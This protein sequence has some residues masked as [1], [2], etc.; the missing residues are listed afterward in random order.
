VKLSLNNIEGLLDLYFD[1]LLALN[2][3]VMNEGIKE[4]NY[5][6]RVFAKDSLDY[7]T[8]T[9]K[10]SLLFEDTEGIHD[11]LG[12]T[13]GDNFGYFQF[14]S[15]LKNTIKVYMRDFTSVLMD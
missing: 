14:S 15:F 12:E 11:I 10:Y 3:R 8:V 9:L 6:L 4:G 5:V 1:V 13:E 7:L 2:K